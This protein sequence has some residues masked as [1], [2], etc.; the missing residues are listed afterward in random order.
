[1]ERF[2]KQMI[3]DFKPYHGTTGMTYED[4]L[5]LLAAE[6]YYEL[7]GDE[8]YL[9]FIN[10]YMDVHLT[11]TG[12]I[13][14]YSV[15]DYNIDNI[16]AGNVLFSLFDRTHDP[17]FINT[18]A[19]LRS[20][21]KTHPRTASGSFWHKK[22][23]PY[24]IWL[25]GL[26]M[27]QVFY[28]Q[29]ALYF[30]ETSI[31]DDVF[32]QVENVRKFLWDDQKKLYVHAYDEQKIMQWADPVTGHSPNVWSRSVGWW[33]M[34]LVDLSELFGRIDEEKQTRIND[35]LKELLEGMLPHR[36]RQFHMWY[37]IVDKP[38]LSGNYL[39]TSGS[40]ML[41]YAMIKGAR[42]GILD[43]NYLS[44]GKETLRGIEAR[45]FTE[46]DGRIY[47]GGICAVAGLDNE[48][49]NGSDAYY[50]S[51]RIA[52]NEIKGVAPFLFAHAELLEAEEV[53][54]NE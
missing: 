29:Y 13:R 47:L 2:L 38:D 16:L 32:Q 4:G 7:T 49:R 31:Y 48:R 5:I 53:K 34:A 20:Q 40:S 50:L 39:E 42:L 26:Y 51:E 21:L 11:D 25:D 9:T 27:G 52:V 6:R 28:L 10:N 12:L 45:Y 43:N 1:M 24:Q 37:Q 14:N 30:E 33:A 18:M 8:E 19:E 46:E 17:R 54:D 15:E 3:A 35:L 41:A 36:D 23:Y 44:Y 22:R